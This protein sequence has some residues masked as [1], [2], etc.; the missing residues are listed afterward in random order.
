MSLVASL[1][2]TANGGLID[3]SN[4]D[5]LF[6]HASDNF[7][8]E[9]MMQF[10][11]ELYTIDEAYM[12]ADIIGSTKVITEGADPHAL[13]ESMLASGIEKIKAAWNKFLAG[14][15]AFFNKVID[16]FKSLVM[17]GKKFVKEFGDK[18]KDKAKGNP[19]WEWN[20]FDYNIGAGDGKVTS[21]LSTVDSKFNDLLG[22]MTVDAAAS[23][24]GSEIGKRAGDGK[25]HEKNI[26]NR[27]DTKDE[28]LKKLG[29]TDD[30]SGLK[31]DLYEIYRGG[32]SKSKQKLGGA[33]G[34]DK[35]M[36]FITSSVDQVSEFTKQ[37]RTFENQAS[38]V[39]NKLDAYSRQSGKTDAE[40][41]LYKY[42][43][44]VSAALNACVE[45][46][47]TIM[48]VRINVYKEAARAY[49]G[50]LKMFLNF[51]GKKPKDVGE[52]WMFEGDTEDVDVEDD[53]DE[54]DVD[55]AAIDGADEPEGDTGDIG[56]VK[57][58]K[59]C[60]GKDCDSDDPLEEAMRYL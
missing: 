1:M 54:V 47:K 40:T 15:K 55:E 52:S 32:D 36:K 59:T 25:D 20:G 27:E 7:I 45:I 31:S 13:M 38:N 17:S 57:E 16:F 37:K 26:P 22:G 28:L 4:Y 18:L 6:E 34:V 56:I 43:S 30:T 19:D 5:Q 46:R 8:D 44:G 24:A 42:V 14:I 41:N 2:Q 48:D 49:T 58:G 10:V 12:T 29:Q 60:D 23:A 9:V 53:L 35:M 50:A 51:G 11:Q 3:T 33:S 39:I 21:Y